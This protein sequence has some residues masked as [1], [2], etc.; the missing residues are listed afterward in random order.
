[1]DLRTLAGNLRKRC[2]RYPKPIP[3]LGDTLAANLEVH[4]TGQADPALWS[5]IKERFA[6]FEQALDAH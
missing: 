1:M 6:E 5:F 3:D 2:R 4:A